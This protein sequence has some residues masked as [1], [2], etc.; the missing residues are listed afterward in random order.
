MTRYSSAIDLSDI[1]QP[2][3]F[4][5][6][7]LR[8]WINEA[9]KREDIALHATLQ[10][11]GYLVHSCN[12]C[13]AEGEGDACCNVRCGLVVQT[14]FV[15]AVFPQSDAPRICLQSYRRYSDEGDGRTRHV[16]DTQ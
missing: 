4:S 11:Q 3:P 6:V 15:V 2:L 7:D 8:S 13:H 12:S 9:R 14:T 1:V 5:A 16:E 10:A